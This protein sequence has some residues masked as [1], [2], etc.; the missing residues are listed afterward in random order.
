[1]KE[2]NIKILNPLT[3]KEKEV[4]YG[5]EIKHLKPEEVLD[6]YGDILTEREKKKISNLKCKV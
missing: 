4:I 1:M 6:V 3:D 5:L 2:S